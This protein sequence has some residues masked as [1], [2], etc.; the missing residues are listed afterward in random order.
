MKRKPTLF[1]A[2]RQRLVQLDG[3]ILFI[4]LVAIVF[5]IAGTAS[6]QHNSPL[7]V[8]ALPTPTLTEN[9]QLDPTPSLLPRELVENQNQTIGLSVAASL[10]VLIVLIGVF[11]ALLPAKR[12][13]P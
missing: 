12:H 4:V 13:T 5:L 6:T 8:N 1:Q 3:R 2:A 11:R 9:L 10:L 7:P